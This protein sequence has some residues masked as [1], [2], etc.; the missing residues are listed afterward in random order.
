MSK[1]MYC[2]EFCLLVLH[3]RRISQTRDSTKQVS[4]TSIGDGDSLVS[5][6]YKAVAQRVI[7][8]IA[9]SMRTSNPSNVLLHKKNSEDCP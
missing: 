3:G 1:Q 4:S 9:T 7:S 2:E 6:D 8:F 5:P